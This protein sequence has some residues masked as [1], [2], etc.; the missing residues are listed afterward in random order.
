MPLEEPAP[1][2]GHWGMSLKPKTR[3][4]AEGSDKPIAFLVRKLSDR[5][6]VER[7]GLNGQE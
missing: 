5:K 7:A 1:D 6:K 4:Q 2:N 3:Q